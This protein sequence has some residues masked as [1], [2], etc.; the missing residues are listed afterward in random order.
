MSEFQS[1]MQQ[2]KNGVLLAVQAHAG[3]KRNA[4]GKVHNHRLRV[5]VTQAP[6]K[7]KANQAIIKLLSKSLKLRKAD[8]ELVTGGT[9]PQ[10]QFFIVDITREELAEKLEQYLG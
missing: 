9:S 5:D 10:K 4:I 2:K 1:A 6:E 7:G 3:A 8:M